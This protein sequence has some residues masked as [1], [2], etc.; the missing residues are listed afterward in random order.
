VE[1]GAFAD[2]PGETRGAPVYRRL[3]RIRAGTQ[4]L[5]VVVPATATWAG[6]DPRSL[7]FDVKPTNNVTRVGSAPR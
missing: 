2:G 5:T 6:V 7:L 4:R 1:V 3:H